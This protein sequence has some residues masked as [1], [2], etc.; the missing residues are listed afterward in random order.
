MTLSPA[1][2]REFC[3]ICGGILKPVDTGLYC[4]TCD[5]VYEASD[6]GHP[7]SDEQSG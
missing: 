6:G 4:I 3:P 1:D 5:L 7:E 2:D